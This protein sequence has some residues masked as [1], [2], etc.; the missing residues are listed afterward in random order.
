MLVIVLAC[1]GL[2]LLS[3]CHS[4]VILLTWHI[5]ILGFRSMLGSSSAIKASKFILMGILFQNLEFSPLY[6]V[7]FHSGS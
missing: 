4:Q 6:S 5:W 1:A 3:F 2:T 7:R